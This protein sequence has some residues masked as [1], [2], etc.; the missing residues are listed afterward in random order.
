MYSEDEIRARTARKML[1]HN[2]KKSFKKMITPL[3][4]EE[5][6]VTPNKILAPHAGKKLQ[7]PL[8]SMRKNLDDRT[9]KR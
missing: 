3:L 5:K 9:D 8:I 4:K 6:M 1:T 7:P 2:L